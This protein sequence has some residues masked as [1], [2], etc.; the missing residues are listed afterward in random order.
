MHHVTST[1]YS[2]SDLGLGALKTC[3]H[4]GTRARDMLHGEPLAILSN[5]RFSTL[6]PVHRLCTR[7]MLNALSSF[8][9]QVS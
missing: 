3:M 2:V 5:S 1:V 6:L 9:F 7:K 8:K 4:S